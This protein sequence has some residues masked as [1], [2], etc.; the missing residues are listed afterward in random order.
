MLRKAVLFTIFTALTIVA[1][2][3][4]IEAIAASK[5][6]TP[7]TASVSHTKYSASTGLFLEV[8]S[9]TWAVRR[10]GSHVKVRALPS[11]VGPNGQVRPSLRKT[12]VIIDVASGNRIALFEDTESKT[13]YPLNASKSFLPYIDRG[14]GGNC[15]NIPAT[16]ETDTMLGYQVR[17]VVKDSLSTGERK[18]RFEAWLAPAL[19]CDPL[20]TVNWGSRNDGPF[21]MLEEIVVTSITPGDP[22]AALF[23]IPTNYVERSP[24]EVQA[25]YARRYNVSAADQ[26]DTTTVDAAYHISRGEPVPINT[27]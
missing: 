24:G 4:G 22:D 10:D 7:Y 25:E 15:A 5:T 14:L 9:G 16:A 27:P 17:K 20:K 6:W 8:D 19:N 23:T 2:R 21:F 13:T 12:R 18:V 11:F 26:C 3:V 1:T